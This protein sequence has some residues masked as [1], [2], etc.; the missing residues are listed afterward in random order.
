MLRI[1]GAPYWST[2]ELAQA[3]VQ[4]SVD[5]ES[6]GGPWGVCRQLVRRKEG[7]R[8]A[9]RAER[10]RTGDPLLAKP[11]SMPLQSETLPYFPVAHCRL[12]GDRVPIS[13]VLPPT[14][15]ARSCSMWREKRMAFD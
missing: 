1:R 8:R 12:G 14:N 2:L 13:D 9:L 11:C 10:D 15:V 4:M 5:R 6:V 7:M 3:P